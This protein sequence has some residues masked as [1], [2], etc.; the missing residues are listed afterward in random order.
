MVLAGTIAILAGSIS[1][2]TQDDLK[3]R[4]AF[5]TVAQVGYIIL[6]FGIVN[7]K[8]LAGTLFYLASHAVIKSL[9]FLSA[10]SIIAVTGKKKVSELAGIGRKMPITMA[11][12]TI[13]SKPYRDTVVFRLYW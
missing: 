6:G 5:S 8:G 10:G 13:A 1:A 9:L 2:M 7:T 11:T 3:R 4:L 12:F